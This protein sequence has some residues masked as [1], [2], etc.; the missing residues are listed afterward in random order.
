MLGK[1]FYYEEFYLLMKL[2][3]AFGSVKDFHLAV[4][5]P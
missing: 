5:I 3:A 4:G 2:Q 1:K